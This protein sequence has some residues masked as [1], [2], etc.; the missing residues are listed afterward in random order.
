MAETIFSLLIIIG[1][2]I[3]LGG[4]NA[5]VIALAS[6]NLPKHLQN[7][8]IFFG[9]GLAILFRIVL[10]I[11]AVK[12]LS[13]AYLHLIGGLLLIYI[14]IKLMIDKK[15]EDV[16]VNASTSLLGAIGTIAFAD[17]I[18]GLDNI[19]AIAGASHGNY[20]L[21][22]FGLF[23]SVPIIIWGS[24]IVLYYMQRFP[25]IIYIGAAILAY[26]AGNMI[27]TE[28]KLNF[29]FDNNLFVKAIF[30]IAIIIFTIVTGYTINKQINSKKQ[31]IRPLGQK[32]S[33]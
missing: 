29:I 20:W 9:T 17:L 19:L 13:I 4:D 30:I 11:T 15:E 12:L 1:I 22:I 33:S 25:R 32:K 28:Q 2:D 10:T 24:K 23:V 7:K 31:I 27:S 26:T 8:A 6:R 5:I 21:V 14:A 3:I 18:M 16:H